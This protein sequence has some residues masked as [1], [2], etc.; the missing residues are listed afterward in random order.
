MVL[1]LEC[2][3]H[4]DCSIVVLAHDV[5]AGVILS[6]VVR[7]CLVG[8]FDCDILVFRVSGEFAGAEEKV[9]IHHVVDDYRIIPMAEVP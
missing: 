6:E 9:Q 4:L 7:H 1:A 5:P 3:L 8:V 2:L